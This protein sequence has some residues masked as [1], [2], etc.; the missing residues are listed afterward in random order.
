MNEYTLITGASSGIGEC[1]AKVLSSKRK[2]ILASENLDLLEF[3]KN[4]CCN[5]E[6]HILWQC[7]F[8]NERSEIF[9]SLLQLLTKNEIVVSEYIHFAG[10]TQILPIKGFTIP[11]VD[12]IF[13]VNFFSIIEIMRILLTKTNK[14][15]LKNIVLISAMASQ[16]GDIGNSIYAAS[17]GAINSLVYSLSQELA[18]NIRINALLPGAIMTQ[19]VKNKVTTDH[20]EKLKK[21]T[22]L[23]I[24]TPEDV[25]N[26]V[27]FLISDRSKYIT[28][29]TLFVDGGRSTK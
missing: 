3:V 14:K 18:P 24:G 6:Q 17:K 19:M 5:P 22:P 13:N 7:D 21:E 16:R 2:L 20:I 4:Q 15:Y 11:Y 23:G 28:G 1:C 8:V 27:E 29:Q 25:V 9:D 12:K 26:Y 10:L